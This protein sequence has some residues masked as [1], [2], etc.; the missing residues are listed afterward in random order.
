MSCLGVDGLEDE[1][2]APEVSREAM[3]IT[4]PRP[5]ATL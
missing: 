3:L 2:S 4:P 5:R 1:Q